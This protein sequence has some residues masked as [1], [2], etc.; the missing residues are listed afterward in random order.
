MNLSPS[1]RE[2]LN[3]VN[4]RAGRVPGGPDTAV[5]FANLESAV[6]AAPDRA[7]E[8]LQ[9]LRE[10]RDDADA[11]AEGA[12]TARNDQ[13]EKVEAARRRLA[14]MKTP[15]ASGGHGL[16]D[17]VPEV[18]A[19]QGRVTELQASLDRAR[20]RQ[21]RLSAETTDL[22]RLVQN[23]ERHLIGGGPQ[24]EFAGTI[25]PAPRNETAR[26]TVD[27]C[28][29]QLTTLRD[30]IGKVENAPLPV[31][32][33]LER[34]R[35]QISELAMRGKPRVEKLLG[36]DPRFAAIEFAQANQRLDLFGDARPASEG[37]ALRRLMGFAAGDVPD[38]VALV[39]FLLHD[40]LQASIAEL[41]KQAADQKAALSAEQQQRRLAELQAEILLI[42]RQEVRAIELAQGQGTTINYR[43][44]TNPKAVLHLA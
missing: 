20:A 1:W 28:R 19:A 21:N 10:T 30:E 37:D 39:A 23:L 32:T 14:E 6:T 34:A 33:A 2:T 26:Q 31:A 9:T 29:Q 5:S 24:H 17:D 16:G 41:V 12:I 11:A 43:I 38:A 40:Q 25:P 3:E 44:D 36:R 27:R 42:E 15:R 8:K 22:R 7:R 18:V 35:D 4:A 13:W